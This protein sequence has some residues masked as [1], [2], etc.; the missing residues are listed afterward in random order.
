M[1]CKNSK[2]NLNRTLCFMPKDIIKF[3]KCFYFWPILSIST[4]NCSLDFMETKHAKRKSAGQFKL[5]FHFHIINPFYDP[6][7]VSYMLRGYWSKWLT[8][9]GSQVCISSVCY[10][11]WLLCIWYWWVN[12]GSAPQRNSQ[13]TVQ[14]QLPDSPQIDHRRIDSFVLQVVKRNTNTKI[15]SMIFKL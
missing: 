4:F 6:K 2:D 13:F 9:C 12:G 1:T 11:G 10:S 3:V 8:A 14:S 15:N 7:E 5:E